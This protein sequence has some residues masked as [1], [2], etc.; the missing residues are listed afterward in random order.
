MVIE[1]LRFGSNLAFLYKLAW[2]TGKLL[3]FLCSIIKLNRLFNS[4]LTSQFTTTREK[5]RGRLK[6]CSLG[7]F[8]LLK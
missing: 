5:L 8:S 1:T 4:Y 6:R 2:P 3:M 7:E